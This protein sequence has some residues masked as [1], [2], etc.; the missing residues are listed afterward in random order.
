MIELARNLKLSPIGFGCMGMTTYYGPAMKTSI[1][2]ALLRSVFDA[3]YTHFDTAEVYQQPKEVLPD[4]LKYNEELVGKFLNTLPAGSF[5]VATKFFPGVHDSR[6]DYETVSQAVD[7]SLARLQLDSVDLYYLHR[8]PPSMELLD[9]WMFSMDRVVKTGRVRHVGLSE[10]PAEWIRRAHRI[11]PVTCVQ[12]EWSLLTREP[13]ESD[14]VPVCSELK[15]AIVAYS[16]LARNLLAIPPKETPDDTR[17]ANPR[18]QER[19]A[20]P[21]RLPCTRRRLRSTPSHQHH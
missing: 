2:E 1:G 15:I 21:L 14:T 18:Y 20:A 8:M 4:T 16:P 5:S 9:E 10:A 6:C 19:C 13:C 3:G 17:A 12:Q 11:H 7:A